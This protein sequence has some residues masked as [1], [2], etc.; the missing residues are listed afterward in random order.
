M[1]SGC[2]VC[3]YVCPDNKI[4]ML[5]F[6]EH[7]LRPILD[8]NDCSTC[9]DCLEI[10]PG[11]QIIHSLDHDH[12][13]GIHELERSWGPVLEVWEGYAADPEIR[14]SGSSAGLATSLAL[15][16]LEKSGMEGVLHVGGDPQQ[17]WKNKTYFSTNKKELMLRTGSR[18]SPSSPC[19]GLGRIEVAQNR[20]IFIGK[21]CDVR[22]LRNAQALK[23]EL[24]QKV[25]L[26][27]G[28]FCAGTPSTQATLDLLKSQNNSLEHIAEIRYRGQ[29]WPGLFAVWEKGKTSPINTIPY[30]K[31]WGFLQAYRPYICHLCPDSTSEFADIS[32]GDP[33]YKKNNSEHDGLSLVLVR[34][35]NGQKILQSAIDAG[36]IMMKKVDPQVLP[37]SQVNLLWK[38]RALWGRLVA[39]SALGIPVPKIKGFHLFANWRCATLIDKIKSIL[40]TWKRVIK[41]KYFRPIVYSPQN[42]RP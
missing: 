26:A 18:Y 4:K 39:I 30:R 13:N 17:P 25:G 11:F 33:W 32:C 10:C 35:K 22:G 15:F 38:R 23:T 12:E 5:D 42:T 34:T 14:Y 24:A 41:R 40:G 16:C 8:S 37:A 21:P 1:C 36:Y 19:D 6:V 2:G 29:G 28:I 31:A 27:I 20:C 7:G 3:A 9:A